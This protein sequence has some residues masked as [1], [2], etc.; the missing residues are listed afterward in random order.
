M[1]EEVYAPVIDDSFTLQDAL[2]QITKISLS[3]NK[4]KRGVRQCSKSLLRSK[5]QLLILSETCEA[6]AKSILIG[7]AKKYNTPVIMMPTLNEVSQLSRTTISGVVK[8]PK[9]HA[10]AVEDYVKKSEGRVFV[11]QM[12]KKGEVSA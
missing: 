1:T 7:L 10:L 3:R 11:E 12:I 4:L 2:A 8:T 9:C 5:T 6:K